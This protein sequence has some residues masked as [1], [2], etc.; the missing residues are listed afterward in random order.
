MSSFGIKFNLFKKNRFLPNGKPEV[1]FSSTWLI[2]FP[3]VY[4]DTTDYTMHT[5]YLNS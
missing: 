3:S 4:I 1:Y 2:V 5:K